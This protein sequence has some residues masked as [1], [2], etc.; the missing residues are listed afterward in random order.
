VHPRPTHNH[1]PI[2]PHTKF[3]PPSLEA[4]PHAPDP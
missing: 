1:A 4:I 2:P 3:I